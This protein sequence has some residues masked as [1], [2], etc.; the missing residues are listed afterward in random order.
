MNKTLIVVL[1]CLG[2]TGLW[3][4]VDDYKGRHPDNDELYELQQIQKDMRWTRWLGRTE[5][6]GDHTSFPGEFLFYW[7]LLKTFHVE[8]VKMTSLPDMKW[9]VSGVGIGWFYRLA[10]FKGVVCLLGLV[11]MGVLCY[12]MG[13]AGVVGFCI[14]CFNPH[15]V[16]HAFDMRPYSVLPILALLNFWLC[17]RRGFE[18]THFIVVVLTCMYHA[19]GP[20]IAFLPLFFCPGRSVKW[21]TCIFVGLA[22]W[23]Y[24]ASFSSFG[25]TA[26]NVQAV[27]SPY[28]YF[29]PSL[30]SYLT[31]FV[32]NG[33]L[34]AVTVPL[35]ALGMLKRR[36]NWAFLACMIVLP[37][38]LIGMVDIKTSYWIHPRQWVW[39]VPFF[40]VWVSRVINDY[41]AKEH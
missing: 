24:Y 9:E 6:Y 19:Y 27:V 25:M 35:V 32:G 38:C 18:R 40:S 4:R 8:R 12:G 10:V 26:N 11:L 41:I 34:Y 17:H 5:G 39:V 30:D 22:V 15:L 2:L 16:Y 7:P 31:S 23:G 29:K 13:W 1:V 3:Q 21:W 33:W 28:K 14:Y 37:L 20:M 36:V